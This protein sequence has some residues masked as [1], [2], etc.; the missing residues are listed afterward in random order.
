MHKPVA[1]CE[2]TCKV[3]TTRLLWI[4]P[5]VTVGY[6]NLHMTISYGIIYDTIAETH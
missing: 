3:M 1:A 4:Y 5:G 2:T 6:V